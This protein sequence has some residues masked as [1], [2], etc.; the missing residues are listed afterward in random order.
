MQSGPE[1]FKLTDEGEVNNFLGIEITRLND[2]SF[3]LSHPFLIDWILNFIGLCK[4]E[5]KM[6]ANSTSTLIAKG[7]L[8]PDLNGKG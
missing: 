3:E 1:N 2:N 6:D 5:F 8:H 4:N 7:L